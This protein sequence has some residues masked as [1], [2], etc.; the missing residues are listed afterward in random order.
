MAQRHVEG[1]APYVDGRRR[2]TDH[3]L[4]VEDWT[5]DEAVATVTGT[6]DATAAAALD[7]AAEAADRCRETTVPQR[8]A[9]C[10]AIAE[11]VRE[12]ERELATT[13]VREVGKPISRARREVEAAAAQFEGAAEAI[14]SLTGEYRTWTSPDRAASNTL[15]R[16]D[17][18]GV[19]VARPS[20]AAPL[21]TAARQIA[22]ALAAGN[23]LVVRPGMTGAVAVSALAE[24]VA[25]SGVP[26]GVINVAPAPTGAASDR[27]AT[28]ER[29]DAVLG[30]DAETTASGVERIRLPL[31]SDGT[32]VVCS[33]ADVDA[34]AATIAEEAL[35]HPGRRNPAARVLAHESVS[36][37]LVAQLDAHVDGW[38]AGDLF[39][40]ATDTAPL[41]DGARVARLDDLVADAVGSGARL[42]R[43]GEADGLAYE[44]TLLTDVPAD[45]PIHDEPFGP[46]VAVTPVASQ[47]EAIA[48]VDAADATTPV[49]FTESYDRAMVVAERLDVATVRINGAPGGGGT[50]GDT[51]GFHDTLTSL[52]RRKRIVH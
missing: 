37:A 25:D 31:G 16:A 43:G 49:V 46:V 5:S 9:W 13:V 40:S 33:D 44:P 48:A 12:R 4:D 24:I 30:T 22:P 50:A 39:D 7:S 10:D 3:A 20:A 28:D 29:I 34:A 21:G 8:S 23:S 32:A 41:A 35:A 19:A 26:T 14:R 2:T 15:V 52:T 11:R 18:L 45:A 42:V 47:P 27:L 6:D 51:V 17:P 38:T 36:D 1:V